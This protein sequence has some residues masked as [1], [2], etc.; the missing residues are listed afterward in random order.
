MGLSPAFSSKLPKA[1][2]PS[3]LLRSIQ[4]TLTAKK[5][6]VYAVGTLGGDI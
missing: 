5:D 3:Y 2:P 4:A 6:F 1:R